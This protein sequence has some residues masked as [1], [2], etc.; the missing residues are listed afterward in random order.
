MET[1]QKVEFV[2]EILTKTMRRPGRKT[3]VL[4]RCEGKVPFWMCG[5]VCDQMQLLPGTNRGD[6]VEI[7]RATSKLQVPWMIFPQPGSLDGQEWGI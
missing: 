4:I 1:S 3:H 7:E 6:N 5:T 2:V